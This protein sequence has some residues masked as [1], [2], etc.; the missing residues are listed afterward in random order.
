M[1]TMCRLLTIVTLTAM[2]SCTQPKGGTMLFSATKELNRA[3]DLAERTVAGSGDDISGL[4]VT[5]AINMMAGNEYRGPTFWRVTFKRR[6]LIPKD[7]SSE[8]GAGGEIFVDVDLTANVAKIA[9]RGE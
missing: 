7:A 9:G 2:L 6:D 4:R 3:I 8:L 1:V 5:A